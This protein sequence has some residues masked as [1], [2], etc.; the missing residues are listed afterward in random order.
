MQTLLLNLWMNEALNCALRLLARREHSAYELGEKLVQK[1]HE[2]SLIPDVL[3]EVQRLGLQSDDRFAQSLFRLRL[4]QGYGPLKI[5]QILQG[6][7]L[8]KSTIEGAF[9]HMEVDWLAQAEAVRVKKFKQTSG[10]MF[11]E[12]QKQQRFLLYRGFPMA[13]IRKLIAG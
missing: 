10:I 4:S 2:K 6:H 11:I 9:N 8:E 3:N 12:L 7:A 13:L 5:R 1:G